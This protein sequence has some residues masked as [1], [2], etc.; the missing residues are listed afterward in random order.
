MEAVPP[1]RICAVGPELPLREYNSSL[2]GDRMAN[3]CGYF[4]ATTYS[5][6]CSLLSPDADGLPTLALT[7]CLP[8]LFGLHQPQVDAAD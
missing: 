6:A 5:V 8:R 1:F 4:A 3:M 7:L 2:H